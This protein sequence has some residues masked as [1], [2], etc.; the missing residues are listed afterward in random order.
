MVRG[1]KPVRRNLNNLSNPGA[2]FQHP[3]YTVATSSPKE[4][5][6]RAICGPHSRFR[7]RHPGSWRS[8][9]VRDVTRWVSLYYYSFT[10]MSTLTSRQ[11]KRPPSAPLPRLASLDAVFVFHPQYDPPVQILQLSCFPAGIPNDPN[12]GPT[13]VQLGLVLEA[14][15][16]IVNNCRGHLE[17]RNTRTVITHNDLDTLLPPGQYHFCLGD[18]SS[19][20]EHED[21]LT[22]Y[23][24]SHDSENQSPYPICDSFALGSLV[25]SYLLHGQT[26]SVQV[27]QTKC[28]SVASRLSA[29]QSS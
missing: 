26:S 14:C 9:R 8:A 28:Q 10:L 17:T 25:T 24:Q 3:N 11:H 12:A 7:T 1:P 22:P 29:W 23:L 16:I 4:L 13:G 27:S 18:G 5:I 20:A 19:S 2:V 6:F 21:L 15:S